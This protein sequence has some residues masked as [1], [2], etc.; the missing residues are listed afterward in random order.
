MPNKVRSIVY[1][2]EENGDPEVKTYMDFSLRLANTTGLIDW[3][4]RGEITCRIVS[5]ASQEIDLTKPWVQV[6][7]RS[8]HASFK[9]V[10]DE[11]EI[12]EEWKA[13]TERSEA[14]FGGS[15]A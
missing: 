14:G 3:D 11:S 8:P 13:S 4:Y 5:A 10:S 9:V 12:P 1:D 6:I 2:S 7:P 15:D